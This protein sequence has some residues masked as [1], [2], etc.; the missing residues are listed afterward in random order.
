MI[1]AMV[2]YV[3]ALGRFV[4]GQF[5]PE[6]FDDK[7]SISPVTSIAEDSIGGPIKNVAVPALDPDKEV[8]WQDPKVLKSILKSLGVILRMPTNW[9]AK[10]ISYWM[11]VESKEATPRDVKD[12]VSGILTGRDPTMDK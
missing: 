10:P 2:P 11:D 5:T 12:I 9:A 6:F 4:Y 3:G 1:T 7:M 8:E